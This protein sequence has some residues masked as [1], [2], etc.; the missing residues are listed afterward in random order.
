MRRKKE[1]VYIQSFQTKEFIKRGNQTVIK[2]LNLPD[3]RDVS[4]NTDVLKACLDRPFEKNTESMTMYWFILIFT[5]GA[6]TNIVINEFP[7][8][9]LLM[10]SD[11]V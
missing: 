5:D 4:A 7:W 3:V 11:N 2:L 8:K 9:G 1:S 10:I 6:S